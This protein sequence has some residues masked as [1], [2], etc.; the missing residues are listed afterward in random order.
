V[1]SGGRRGGSSASL[2]TAP[3]R[4]AAQRA[5]P[6]PDHPNSRGAAAP[7]GGGALPSSSPDT[8]TRPGRRGRPAT[9]AGGCSPGGPGRARAV[10]P[11][12]TTSTRSSPVRA[13]VHDAMQAGGPSAAVKR[14]WCCMA[15]TT[16]GA[17]G[18]LHL[19]SRRPCLVSA[20]ATAGTLLGSSLGPELDAEWNGWPARKAGARAAARDA[21]S[22]SFAAGRCTVA[23]LSLAVPAWR[24]GVPT[25]RAGA[26]RVV[27]DEVAGGTLTA[28]QAQH[29]DLGKL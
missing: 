18:R 13:L 19:V 9:S 3:N 10:R 25:A 27:E 15:R 6:H 4:P 11:G 23:A 26:C 28:L 5:G 12:S 22:A 24:F 7:S 21:G 17:G 29:V 2:P 8:Q 1:R 16:A 14:F 20:C